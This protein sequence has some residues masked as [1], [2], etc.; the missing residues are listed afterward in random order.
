M[1]H[2]FCDATM[3]D[4]YGAKEDAMDTE[5]VSYIFSD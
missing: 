1:N 4:M 2:V 5:D 3:K